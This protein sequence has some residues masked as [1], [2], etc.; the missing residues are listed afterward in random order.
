M[1]R[2]ALLQVLLRGSSV[3]LVVPFFEACNTVARHGACRHAG[4][5]NPCPLHDFDKGFNDLLGAAYGLYPHKTVEE[6]YGEPFGTPDAEM[7]AH[8][9]D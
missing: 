5:K 7:L 9:Q 4:G 1:T 8:A 6:E 3:S 2:V